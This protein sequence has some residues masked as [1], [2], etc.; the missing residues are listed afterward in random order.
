MEGS[1]RGVSRITLRGINTGGVAST[2]G[3][4][5]DEVPFGSSSGLANG[6]ILAGDFDTSDMARLEVLRG[7]QGTLYGASSLGGVMKFVTNPPQMESFEGN[8]Q[9]GIEDVSGGDLSY[10]ANSYVNIPLSERFA[11]RATG[12][13]RQDG[14][15]VDSIGNNPIPSLTDP[16]VNIVQGSL[17]EDNINELQTYGGRFSAL[18]NAS[19]MLSVRLTALLQNIETDASDAIQTDR[20]TLEPLYGDRVAS[21]YH[22]EP[23]DIRV[24]RLQRHRR[25]GS[26]AGEPD[27]LDQL[28]YFPGGPAARPG[29]CPSAGSPPSCFGDPVT[30]PL[31]V[32]LRQTTGTDKFTQELRLSSP[33]ERNPGVARRRLLHAGKIQD[34]SPGFLRR[35]SRHRNDRQ[36]TSRRSSRCSC[37]RST[38]N[39]PGSP[40]SPGTSRRVS[41]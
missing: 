12:F 28:R 20:V 1:T 23:T 24:S 35:R 8:A 17:D 21:P 39:M 4:Y 22:H 18:F 15:F 37:D 34:R 5:V 6:A 14:G 19:D 11:V 27:V 3:V 10:S 30:R 36:R 13:Y 16:D 7:P 25:L 33:D 9:V 41:M 31:S 32:I 38:R 40:I 26:R 29:S 2:V